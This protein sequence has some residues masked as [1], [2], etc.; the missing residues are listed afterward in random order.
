MRAQLAPRRPNLMK[1]RNIWFD[2]Q[3]PA[4]SRDHFGCVLRYCYA[5][6]KGHRSRNSHLVRI[7]G[8][9]LMDTTSD[10]FSDCVAYPLFSH[11]NR[12]L[13]VVAGTALFLADNCSRA[14]CNSTRSERE[15][16]I[17]VFW[18]SQPHRRI[19]CHHPAGAYVRQLSVCVMSAGPPGRTK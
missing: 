1:D 4:F 19:N 3:I 14:L 5:R 9:A 8:E 17:C 15:L 7:S 10:G 12:C 18:R 2:F 6:C 16:V 11:S 13:A